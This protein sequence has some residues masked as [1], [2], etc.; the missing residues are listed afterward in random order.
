MPVPGAQIALPSQVP[1][2]VPH[3]DSAFRVAQTPVWAPCCPGTADFWRESAIKDLASE[4]NSEQS[5][6]KSREAPS[7]ETGEESECF[8]PA[9]RLRS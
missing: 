7:S 6:S 9:K 2:Q 8:K 4:G 3:K 1:V 5:F